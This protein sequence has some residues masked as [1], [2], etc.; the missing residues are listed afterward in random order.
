MLTETMS[1]SAESTSEV[2]LEASG[3]LQ[4]FGSLRV[5]SGVDLKLCR[6]EI[7]G[8]IGPS[9]GG[10]SVLLKM[11]SNV[12]QPT[13]GEV[14]RY[15]SDEG[16][17]SFMFQEGA[18]FDSVS[19]LDNIAF[20]LV[21][22]RVPSSTLKTEEKIMLSG[23]VGAILKKVGLFRHGHKYPAQLSGGMRRRVSLARA[24]VNEPEVA[25]LDD[26]TSGLDPVASSVI[27]A[28]IESLHQS[29]GTSMILVSHDLRRLLPICSRIIALFNGQIVFDGTLQE[30]RSDASMEVKR[31]V[32]CRFDLS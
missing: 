26:P 27:M 13:E 3:L 29:L 4:Q 1:N 16:S 10:K 12:L 30:L 21:Q 25:L 23:K 17:V 11:L 32:S 19:V 6:G 14:R 20:P 9:G 22:G 2:V 8:L 5:L 18:L 15:L 7:V 28:L 24:L 31:F